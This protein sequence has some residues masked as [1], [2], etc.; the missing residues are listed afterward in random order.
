MLKKISMVT[1]VIWN[2]I[3]IMK[4]HHLA[5]VLALRLKKAYH[6]LQR[7]QMPSQSHLGNQRYQACPN[8]HQQ[9]QA[10]NAQQTM[11][12][13]L[14]HQPTYQLEVMLQVMNLVKNHPQICGSH[15]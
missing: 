12:Q 13:I 14:L 15:S 1:A 6:R 9:S 5:G 7:H 11:L 8:M 2:P 10:I 4:W 3:Q